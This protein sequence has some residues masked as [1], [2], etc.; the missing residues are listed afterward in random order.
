MSVRITEYAV[1]ETRKV[2]DPETCS[3]CLKSVRGWFDLRTN[4]FWG[5]NFDEAADAIQIEKG[6]L[7]ITR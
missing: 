6:I 5:K 3:N 1:Y 4:K 2:A 7:E